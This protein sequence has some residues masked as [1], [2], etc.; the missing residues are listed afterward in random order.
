MSDAHDP[1]P[2]LPASPDQER[3]HLLR[4]QARALILATIDEDG[5]P[6]LSTL[7]FV[8]FEQSFWVLMSDLSP[9]T[10][11]VRQSPVVELM[12][13]EDEVKTHNIYNRARVTWRADVMRVERND[14]RS[15]E[16][17]DGLRA[18]HGKIVDVL[19]QLPDFHLHR[20]V[21]GAGRLVNGFGRAF[22]IDGF[23]LVAHLRGS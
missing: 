18:R 19:T 15:R 9:H 3:L 7:P 23:D 13:I 2:A 21:P 22:K 6:S 5:F 10:K 20:M 12:L 17:F 8:W 16:V 14:S 1:S 11:Q 4:E